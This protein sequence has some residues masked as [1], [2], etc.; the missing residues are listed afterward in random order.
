MSHNADIPVVSREPPIH[1][2]PSWSLGSQP[3]SQTLLRAAAP[4]FG[5]RVGTSVM[6]DLPQV[7]SICFLS[8][9]LVVE[10]HH[11]APCS[12][13]S[14]AYEEMQPTS[15]SP[16]LGHLALWLIPQV[17]K[18]RGVARNTESHPTGHHHLLQSSPVLTGHRGTAAWDRSGLPG[19]PVLFQTWEGRVPSFRNLTSWRTGLSQGARSLVHEQKPSSP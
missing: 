12:P 9:V 6:E 8:Q 15:G 10:S 17:V 16:L 3:I 2:G 13:Q 19:C 5:H 11:P 4:P 14:D 7:G 18:D 1:T